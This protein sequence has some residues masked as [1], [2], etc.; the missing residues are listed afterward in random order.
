[1]LFEPRGRD[2]GLLFLLDSWPA[3]SELCCTEEAF[4]GD[5]LRPWGP[6]LIIYIPWPLFHSRSSWRNSAALQ[7]N[8][9]CQMPGWVPTSRHTQ[10]MLSAGACRGQTLHDS[11]LPYSGIIALVLQF[12]RDLAAKRNSCKE[13]LRTLGQCL[14]SKPRFFSSFIFLWIP[15]GKCQDVSPPPTSGLVLGLPRRPTI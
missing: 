10:G 8:I 14:C 13:Y 11:Q 5:Y 2:L 15:V 7:W 3:L 6:H 9:L 12:G 1:M 4:Q